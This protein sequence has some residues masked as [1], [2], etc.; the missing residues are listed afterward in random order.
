MNIQIIKQSA[1]A[2]RIDANFY[3]KNYFALIKK[4]KDSGK[5]KNWVATELRN[6]L[7]K[8]E[9]DI[10]GGATP[11]GATYLEE[12][13]PFLRVQNIR[14]NRLFLK[15][16]KFIPQFI[17]EGDL[18]RSQLKP[19]DVLLTITG[20][21]YGLSCV[22][23]DSLPQA[24]MNQHSVRIR[25]DE[26]TILPKFLSLFLNNGLGK[27]QSDRFITGSTRPA[28]D[29][30]SV[31]SIIVLFPENLE[32]QEKIVSESE[33]YLT[34]AHENIEQLK[35]VSNKSI[36]LISNILQVE[37]K[38]HSMQSF[39]LKKEE[40]DDRFDCYYNCPARKN[41][42]ADITKNTGLKK[43]VLITAGKLNIVDE[44]IDFENNKQKIYKYVDIG[45]TNKKSSE[46]IG[47]EEDALINLPSRAKKIMREN[48]VL[49]PRPIGSTEGVIIVPKEFDGQLCSTGFTQ[50]RPKNFNDA[51]LLWGILKSNIVQEQLFYLQ[52]GSLQPEISPENFKEKVLIPLPKETNEKTIEQSFKEHLKSIKQIH[53]DL[54][55]NEKLAE[56]V[57][58]NNLIK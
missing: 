8:S 4:L 23:P 3:N 30:E 51:F 45:N 55:K 11:L 26:K 31:K 43:W 13:I 53:F 17:H 46:I 28:L 22:I 2:D 24:N 20:V 15:N 54:Q 7:N 36:S 49:I 16:L 35:Q 10:T 38:K 48:D 33:K 19:N 57:F 9:K 40:Q 18:Q 1:L 6:L 56:D 29:Y 42:I 58:A 50:I 41:L 52:S 27:T 25:V 37:V 21:T 47:F 5:K 14:K 34:K 32:Q 12:G 44:L 39:V